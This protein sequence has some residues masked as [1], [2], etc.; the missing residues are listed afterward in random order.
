MY[1]TY[2]NRHKQYVIPVGI[3]KPMRQKGIKI[4]L[5]KKQ[6]RKQKLIVTSKNQVEF[7]EQIMKFYIG[8]IQYI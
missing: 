7:E 5:K 1:A 3:G 2:I 4:D 8:S 6:K